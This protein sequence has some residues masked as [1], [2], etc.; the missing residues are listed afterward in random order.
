MCVDVLTELEIA[1]P[2]SVVAAFTSDPDTATKW[3]E[4]ID[5]VEWKTQKTLAAG[6]EV[7]FTAIFLGRRLSYV[8]RIEE[9]V[10]ERRLVMRTVDGPF[11]METTY[12]WETDR[13][14]GRG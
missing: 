13:T 9:L 1:R 3:Y 12:S 5:S 4:N 2:R 11:A 10:P 14:E 6:A 7:A 8:Y